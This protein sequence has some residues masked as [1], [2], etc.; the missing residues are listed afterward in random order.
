[1]FLGHLLRPINDR[2]VSLTLP[3]AN[4]R[5]QHLV[6][7]LPQRAPAVERPRQRAPRDRT[8]W[9][10]PDAR[11]LAVRDHLSFL[12]A[13]DQIVEVLHADELVQT[14][15]RRDVLQRLELPRG[16]GRRADVADLAG[17]DDVVEGLHDFFTG[18]AAVEPVDLEDLGA[19]AV[20][21]LADHVRGS[22]E[23]GGTHVNVRAQ[24]LDALVHG[25]E[26][27][28]PAQPHLVDHVAVVD[29]DGANRRIRPVLRHAE[30]AF[31]E[32]D[33]SAAR[34]VVLLQR[35]AHDPLALPH[36]IHVRR[37]PG[38]EPDVVRV[39]EKRQR[40]LLVKDPPLPFWIAV[41]HC[42]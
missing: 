27:M 23:A 37:V 14:T 7:L 26:D 20:S 33:D 10:Q 34:D 39:L 36:G 19:E 3:R 21:G 28:L 9:D 2:L 1:M 31:A 4:H 38:V 25:V 40:L 42:A 13:V 22:R 18:R 11:V 6:R 35:L 24:A 32:D 5:V 30:V 17:L 8:P 12:L 41:G 16:H 29:A 15:R